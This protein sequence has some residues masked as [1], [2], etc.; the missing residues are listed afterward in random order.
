MNEMNYT[1]NENS[2]NIYTEKPYDIAAEALLTP[3]EEYDLARRAKNG[4]TEARDRLVCA[5]RRLVSMVAGKYIKSC[6]YLEF[7]DLQQAGNLGLMQAV[8]LFDCDKG[9]RFSTYAI[10]WIRQAITREISDKDRTVRLPIHVNEQLSRIRRASAKIEQKTGNPAAPE[11]IAD[12]LGEDVAKV[13]ELLSIAYAA[14]TVSM[15]KPLGDDDGATLGD[16]LE[17]GGVSPQETAETEQLRD[18]INKAVAMLSP[19]EQAVIKMRF[20]M[21]DG[22]THTL[23]EVGEA[24]NVTR[25]RIRQIES[26]ALR[27]LRGPKFAALLKG[28]H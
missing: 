28:F 13:N 27:K 4:D 26:K 23:E 14:P 2:N 7:D 17:D 3:E 18:Q 22:R 21:V 15:D 25:E 1:N 6:R 12:F 9:Y 19:R 8:R 16:M 10:W 5:N 11:E 20:G 24:Y